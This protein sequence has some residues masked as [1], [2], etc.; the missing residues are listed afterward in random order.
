ME[1]SI[2][3]KG[4]IAFENLDKNLT[5]WHFNLKWNSLPDVFVRSVSLE[6]KLLW[7]EPTNGELQQNIYFQS[8]LV[9]PKHSNWVAME[10]V[11]DIELKGIL[12]YHPDIR[13]DRKD[14]AYVRYSYNGT[15]IHIVHVVTIS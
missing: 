11:K 15:E 14:A 2:V 4:K 6:A 9:L 5:F 8:R 10:Y 12:M 3:L 13:K 7:D 1:V